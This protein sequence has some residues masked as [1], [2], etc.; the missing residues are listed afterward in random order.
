MI[1]ERDEI[2]KLEKDDA[3]DKIDEYINQLLGEYLK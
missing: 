2:L 1:R 3:S